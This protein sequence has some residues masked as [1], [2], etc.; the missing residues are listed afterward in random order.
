[1]GVGIA[2]STFAPIA[3]ELYA[4]ERSGYANLIADLA[5]KAQT[6]IGIAVTEGD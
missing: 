4:G 2:A 6:K 3:R 5:A 1:M